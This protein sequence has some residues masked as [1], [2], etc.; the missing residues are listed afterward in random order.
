VHSSA[1]LE[2]FKRH[3][4][5]LTGKEFEGAICAH[6]QASIHSFKRISDD[7]GD[8]GV[9]GVSHNGEHGYCCY[10]PEFDSSTKSNDRV[11]A[12]V[13]K[14]KKDMCRLFEF[15]S[16]GSLFDTPNVEL[17]AVLPVG[18]RMRNIF[19]LTTW[20]SDKRIYNR[21]LGAFLKYRASSECRFVDRE[22]NMTVMGP[23]DIA[24]AYAIT[25]AT[26]AHLEQGRLLER[27]AQIAGTL[28]PIAS[29]DFDQKMEILRRIRPDRPEAVNR[30]AADAR[31]GWQMSLA[32]EQ[33]LAD[34]STTLHAALENAR[35]E[36]G[37]H[38]AAE[39]IA[40]DRPWERLNAFS[41]FAKTQI[42]S[43]LG[44][45]YEA[46]AMNAGY[47]EIARLIGECTIGWQEP[48]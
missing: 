13:D 39:M 10:G 24:V 28:A 25:E 21:L 16:M 23:E 35:V 37:S 11:N 48:E 3:L 22:A 17:A 20:A 29:M 15:Q 18:V 38:V 6:L 32:L 42:A 36:I 33:N 31:R 19:F 40:T 4:S 41:S 27:V 46:I 5:A 9:D 7:D 8:G 47:G 45:D 30:F 2:D 44:V 12:I 26:L 43:A 14:F 1:R 34:I